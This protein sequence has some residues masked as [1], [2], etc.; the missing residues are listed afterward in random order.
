MTIIIERTEEKGKAAVLAKA[1]AVIEEDI[2][3]VLGKVQ[4]ILVTD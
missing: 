4:I 1:V 3:E 2:T